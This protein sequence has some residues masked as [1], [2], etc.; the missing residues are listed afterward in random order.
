MTRVDP[1]WVRMKVLVKVVD[2]DERE[3]RREEKRRRKSVRALGIADGEI[4]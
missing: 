1:E 3:G 4:N 2:L